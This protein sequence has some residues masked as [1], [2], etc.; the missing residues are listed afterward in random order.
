MLIATA[1]VLAGLAQTAKSPARAPETDETVAVPRG[2][3]LTVDNF[4]GDVVIHTWDKNA[5]H[6][7]ARHQSRTTVRVRQTPGGVC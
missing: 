3:R 2:A 5:L 4:A 7:V 1:L 6:V